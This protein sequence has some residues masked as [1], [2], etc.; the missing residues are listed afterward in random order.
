MDSS[1][2][3]YD[4]NKI[5]A[6]KAVID[7]FP[8]LAEYKEFADKKNDLLLRICIWSTDE[9]SP[10]VVEER[11]DY[12]RLI[13]NI[14]KYL[15]VTDKKIITSITLGA[16]TTFNQMVNR[17][18]IQCDNLAYIMW[19]DKFMMFHYIGIALRAPVNMSNIEMEM[20]KRA[21][22]ELKR[23]AIHSSL[24][25]YESQVF[26]TTFTRKVVRKEV[27]KML[28]MAEKFAQEKSVI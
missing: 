9:N 26:H 4:L 2:M 5:P 18:F 14:C 19:K 21:A 3:R 23:E 11:D 1:K 6:N 12:E 10:F 25:Q 24:V 15:K 28:Q 22:L 7:H 20:T 8:E 16:E 17:Y 27:A 13:S